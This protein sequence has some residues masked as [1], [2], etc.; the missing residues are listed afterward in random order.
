MRGLGTIVGSQWLLILGFFFLPSIPPGPKRQSWWFKT[1][2]K[3]NFKLGFMRAI[4]TAGGEAVGLSPRLPA[5]H[6]LQALISP[7][8][9]EPILTGQRY[10]FPFCFQTY[11]FL[12]SLSF[13]FFFKHWIKLPYLAVHIH[14]GDI[15]RGTDVLLITLHRAMSCPRPRG[16]PPTGLFTFASSCRIQGGGCWFLTP[17]Q[18]FLYHNVSDISS[19]KFSDC[20]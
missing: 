13:C 20:N 7:Q 14:L 17:A 3:Q 12:F 18:S 1:Q 11:L 5:I 16:M 8:Q 6:A 15:S 10:L 19:K 9:R 4:G 2:N